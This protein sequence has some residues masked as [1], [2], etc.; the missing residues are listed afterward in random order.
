MKPANTQQDPN[1]R[2]EKIYA[3]IDMLD[4]IQK[5]ICEVYGEDILSGM[6]PPIEPETSDDQYDIPF[7]DQLD[8]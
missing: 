2:T 7:D 8:F 1:N 6:Q 3:I 5:L 4:E